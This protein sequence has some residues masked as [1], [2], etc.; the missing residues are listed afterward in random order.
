MLV[1]YPAENQ[2]IRESEEEQTVASYLSFSCIQ[3]GLK[4]LSSITK[5]TCFLSIYKNPYPYKTFETSSCSFGLKVDL[6]IYLFILSQSYTKNCKKLRNAKN[7]R[8]SLLRKSVPIG[9]LVTNNPEIT[10]IQL[11]VYR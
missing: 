11:A 7:G 10:C 9:Y 8:N 3:K 6:I 2:N 5:I 4:Y 1:R